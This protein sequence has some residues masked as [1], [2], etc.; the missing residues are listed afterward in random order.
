ME[1]ERKFLLVLTSI[2]KYFSRVNRAYFESIPTLSPG[3]AKDYYKSL[4][5]IDT[6][7]F[8]VAVQSFSNINRIV[9][10]HINMKLP[11]SKKF[12]P[13][14]IV[15]KEMRHTTNI[16]S[17]NSNKDSNSEEINTT[18]K[19]PCQTINISESTNESSDTLV[20]PTNL[21]QNTSTDTDD[22]LLG[23]VYSL[24]DLSLDNSTD[25]V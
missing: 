25:E 22:S 16:N 7:E 20:S 13:D 4:D 23:A 6:M 17:T 14:D 12:A 8:V 18:S 5:F 19:T 15:L 10:F 2:Q 24:L 9:W 1:I 21:L 3:C 11:S